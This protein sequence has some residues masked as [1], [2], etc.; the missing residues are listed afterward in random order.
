MFFSSV[1]IKKKKLKTNSQIVDNKLNIVHFIYVQFSIRQVFNSSLLINTQKQN[2]FLTRFFV[3]CAFFFF[4]VARL[5]VFMPCMTFQT[6]ANFN[7]QQPPRSLANSSINNR[8]G[9]SLLGGNSLSGHV[10]PTSGMFPPN[11]AGFSSQLSPNRG[12]NV[13]LSNAGTVGSGNS[14]LPSRTSLFGQRSMNDRRQVP[15]LGPSVRFEQ[16]ETENII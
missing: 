3:C 12:G 8:G 15:S 2:T 6:M 5:V 14:N 16:S 9:N 10:T 13:Q 7:F 4:F 1:F 11:N